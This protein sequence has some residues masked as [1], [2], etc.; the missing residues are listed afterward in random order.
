MKKN[1]FQSMKVLTALSLFF[2][3]FA[4]QYALAAKISIGNGTGALSSTGNAVTI[5]ADSL[6]A[7]MTMLDIVIKY[8]TASLKPQV[9]ITTATANF[10]SAFNAVLKAGASWGV[11][12]GDIDGATNELHITIS[13]SSLSSINGAVTTPLDLMTIYFDVLAGATNN[14]SY[15]LEVNA[16]TSLGL[17]DIDGNSLTTTYGNGT[18]CVG[19][20]GGSTPPTV[21]TTSPATSITTTGATV[22][23]NVSSE[24]SASVT[25]RG[26]CVATTANPT[27]G[28]TAAATAGAGAFSV[29]LT[30][31]TPGTNYFARAYATSTAGTSYGTDV[32][33]TTLATP[34]A[35][36]VTTATPSA[37][38]A[39]TA[40]SGGNVTS[41]GGSSVTARGVC[42][43]TADAPAIGGTGVV[44]TTDGTGTG[45]F[46]SSLTGLTA[47]TSYHIRAYATNANGTA[48]GSD[49]TFKTAC[50]TPTITPTTGTAGTA[51]NFVT[52]PPTSGNWTF[53]DPNSTPANPNTATD[54][55]NPSH[56]YSSAGTY[57]VT[58]TVG[59]CST[60]LTVSIAPQDCSTL[61]N[62]AFTTSISG[63][64][65]TVAVSGTALGTYKVDFGDGTVTDPATLPITHTY[66]SRGVKTITVTSTNG[67]CTSTSSKEVTVD[68]AT[69]PTIT[70]PS[71]PITGTV[72]TAIDFTASEAVT[73][74]FGDGGTAASATNASHAYTQAGTY[75]VT[76]VAASGCVNTATVT[77]SDAACE[78]TPGNDPTA[79]I[80]L[81]TDPPLVNKPYVA[82]NGTTST[83]TDPAAVVWAVS[84]LTAATDATVTVSSTAPYNATITFPS[85]GE[86]LIRLTTTVGTC[87]STDTKV[88]T[89][90]PAK[91]PSVI[92]ANGATT[93]PSV[94]AGDA[95][96][97]SNQNASFF[98]YSW[99]VI[100]APDPAYNLDMET[101]S[102]IIYSFPVVGTY[103]VT[104]SGIGG[105]GDTTAVN[106]T[107]IVS[108]QSIVSV[109]PNTGFVGDTGVVITTSGFTNTFT[110]G[111]VT[112]SFGGTPAT[113]T[114]VDDDTAKTVTVTV[115]NGTGTVDVTL[116]AGSQTA[117][118]IGAFTY[119][120]TGPVINTLNPS[121]GMIGTTNYTVTVNGSNFEAGNARAVYCTTT[122][123]IAA[124]TTLATLP[125]DCTAISGT[126]ATA[127]AVSNVVLPASATA[128]TYYV[129]VFNPSSGLWSASKAFTVNAVT[130]SITSAVSTTTSTVYAGVATQLRI[131][132]QGTNFA[133]N[134]RVYYTSSTGAACGTT[135]PATK[136]L[137]GT[138][139]TSP[140]PTATSITTQSV[141][142]PS[143]GNYCIFVCDASDA[144]CVS[145]NLYANQYGGGGDTPVVPP[146]SFA[147]ETI[148]ANDSTT[149]IT[150]V[151]DFTVK[152]ASTV[153]GSV[154]SYLWDFGDGE[155]STEVTPT[156][157]YKRPGLYTVKLS[158]YAFLNLSSATKE[159]KDFVKVVAAPAAN[160][161]CSATSGNAPLTVTC[162]ADTYPG[163]TQ[164]A[165]SFGDNQSGEG[166]SVSHT[167]VSAGTF[168]VTLTITYDDAAL[169]RALKTATATA[170]IV[171]NSAMT[172]DMLTAGFTANPMTGTK[173]LTVNFDASASA[174]ANGYAW[175]FGDNQTGSGKT[176]SHT[177]A[178]AGTYTVTLKTT[179][180]GVAGCEKSA[181]QTITVTEPVC[182]VTAS[183]TASKLSGDVPLIVNFDASASAKAT[184][185]AWTFGDG[186]SGS[187]VTATHTYTKAG[188]YTVTLT[189]KDAICTKTATKTI[190]AM[191]TDRPSKPIL[192]SPENGVT[193]R[194]PL[195]PTLK[196]QSNYSSPVN[197]PHAK[198]RWQI[199]T[200]ADFKNVVYDVT[201]TTNL[202]SIWVPDFMLMEDTKYWWRAQYIDN[203]GYVSDWADPFTMLT[204]QINPEDVNGNGVP[205]TQEITDA[206]SDIDAN[207]VADTK[208]T[209]A[210]FAKMGTKGA[211]GIKVI[212]ANFAGWLKYID[213]KTLPTPPAGYEFPWGAMT[214]RVE[215]KNIGDSA[216][217]TI[218]FSEALPSGAKWFNYNQIEGWKDY[219]QYAT[220]SAN[221]KV[222]TL[223]LK[224]G[225]VGDADGTAN[226]AIVD[227]AA[228]GIPT[229]APAPEVCL[230]CDSS[231]GCFI[232]TVSGAGVSAASAAMLTL[233][234]MTGIFFGRRRK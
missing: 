201:N 229:T 115:P 129:F 123:A 144:N 39:T 81:S 226:G 221:R 112:V 147:I 211:S 3:L 97:F 57:T 102:P 11:D 114:A 162:T 18:F 33:F 111:G 9:P 184:S 187:G 84:K 47:S 135:L 24:G 198:T 46:T 176:V 65:V 93:T 40:T 161:I 110:V 10:T 69:K 160:F 122:T 103:T 143:V 192:L 206:N 14:T 50:T 124:G 26:I 120:V 170:T 4:G 80:S 190:Q 151:T 138:P 74:N 217:I 107:V 208:Q 66:T 155:T 37:I 34:T 5:S 64:E 185:F 117:T 51:V 17:M 205:E 174:N 6:P 130:P 175:N 116:T 137:I 186:E 106:M 200:D 223:T 133:A 149:Q 224:D 77:I 230:D 56:T 1:F 31:L 207:G 181:T 216:V 219:S 99:W 136:T 202:T 83:F 44:C 156:H 121:S 228:I 118:K 172:C 19:T 196:T 173:P 166:Q 140:A 8:D 197:S 100:T 227:P 214:F 71:A 128:T 72:G 164:Y 203:R 189:A 231:G 28:C 163:A 113:V 86:Y 195:T 87:T 12:L 145:Y 22:S 98:D 179:N 82:G 183:F 126:T 101:G 73:W 85:T 232:S 152:F 43:G 131:T 158:I 13:E 60:S 25:A 125:V 150:G 177:F 45:S 59:T 7:A 62:S 165:W 16:T 58:Y 27:T 222:V 234:T 41:D 55:A 48:Y 141:T 52:T 78:I 154:W 148:T 21:T 105:T 146:P 90:E 88:V 159:V 35:P 109:S 49:L 194:V 2:F 168:V 30:G 68:C 213:M 182:E 225:G 180:S 210:I 139:V 76:I 38:T 178:T 36:T 167:F 220:F 23:G 108:A 61:T 188:T 75:T 94:K 233:V 89:V 104:L 212:A 127:T 157:V 169:T 209:D 96:T 42:Y 15:S 91:K 29:T 32:Q 70:V 79:K 191:A 67:T 204:V 95:V 215:T 142:F 119:N 193:T 153:S 171:V 63:L 53:G 20:C 134:S 54:V 218:Y 132:G 92:L 199:A